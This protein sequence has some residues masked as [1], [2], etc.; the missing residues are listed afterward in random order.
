MKHTILGFSC[1]LLMGLF[2]QGCGSVE[3]NL[4]KLFE[5]N[6]CEKCDLS[7]ADLTNRG[8][9]YKANLKEANLTEANLKYVNLNH[10]DLTGANLTEADLTGANLEGTVFLGAKNFNTADTTG[11]RFC[12]T[13]M[14][15]GSTKSG[16]RGCD[17]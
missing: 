8:L 17:M 13:I 1:L 11:A 12:K 15:D 7:G 5:T 6:A 9:L 3:S 4:E 2:L 10:A 16:G 14:P